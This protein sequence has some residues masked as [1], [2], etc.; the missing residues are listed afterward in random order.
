MQENRKLR[1]M[2]LDAER[3]LRADERAAGAAREDAI[4]KEKRI[5]ADIRREE[6]IATEAREDKI[7]Q[8]RKNERAHQLAMLQMQLE[9]SKNPK[10]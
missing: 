6:R 2:E 7:R 3:E 4:R 5:A 9:L 1:K 8:Q 10:K